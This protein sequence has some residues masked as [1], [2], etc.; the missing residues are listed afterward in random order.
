MTTRL[1]LA[2]ACAG[3]LLAAIPLL[4]TKQP[5]ETSYIFL[6]AVQGDLDLATCRI[7]ESRWMAEGQPGHCVPEGR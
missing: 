6:G 3:I 4:Q 7:L 2:A 5:Y 1:L